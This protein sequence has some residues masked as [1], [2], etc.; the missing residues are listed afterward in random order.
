MNVA[1]GGASFLLL[2]TICLS[3]AS[4]AGA[5]P[6]TSGGV[7]CAVRIVATGGFLAL[8]QA[9]GSQPSLWLRADPADSEAA[10]RAPSLLRQGWAPPAAAATFLA[11]VLASGAL[12]SLGDPGAMAVVLPEPRPLPDPTRAADLLLL[13]PLTE[14]LFFRA[15]LLTALSRAGAGAAGWLLSPLLFAAWHG[16][17]ADSPVFFG[18][19]GLW[20]TALYRTSGGSLPLAVGTHACF[21][22]LVVLLRAARY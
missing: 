9:G 22:G 19:L 5:D 16:A 21:N 11:L 6:T 7:A 18:L 15:F 12:L 10:E 14:E 8:Q 13:A 4:L 3:A 2:H 17:V 20:L 1:V